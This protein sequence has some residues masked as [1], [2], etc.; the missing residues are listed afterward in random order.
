MSIKD[1]HLALTSGMGLAGFAVT[2]FKEYI[3]GAFEIFKDEIIESIVKPTKRT[4]IHYYLYYFQDIEEDM[5]KLWGSIEPESIYLYAVQ[6]LQEVDL[7]PELSSVDFNDC[8]NTSCTHYDCEIG[9]K[10]REWTGYIIENQEQINHLIVHSAFQFIFQDRYFLQKFH[11][12]LSQFVEENIEYI[13]A[14]YPDV[15]TPGNRIKR[16][17]FPMWL[18]NAVYYRDKA[19]CSNRMCR[20][21]L[22]K[23]I[24]PQNKIHIDHIVPLNLYGSNDASNFQLLCESCNTSKGDRSASTSAISIPC[25]NLEQEKPNN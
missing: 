14:N 2:N 6:L 19:T 4:A 20:C 8:S 22:S 18:K 13:E 16:Q 25:W 17:Y 24:R 21:D 7:Y 3:E 5:S 15:V 11:L 10:I 9:E 12:R 1:E 23:R